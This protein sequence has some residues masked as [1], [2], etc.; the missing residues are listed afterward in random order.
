MKYLAR[1][2]SLAAG[3]LLSASSLV[4]AQETWTL[5]R[6]I[7][8]AQENNLS[9]M[10]ARATVRTA[11]LS[12]R[13][14]R[15]GRL[16]TVDGQI[17]AGEQFGRTIDPTT[18]Q[19]S[20]TAVGYNSMGL[21]AGASLF[22]GGLVHHRIKQAGFE[23]QAAEADAEQE[24]N[25]LALRVAQAYLSILLGQEQTEIAQRRVEQSRRQLEQTDKLIQAGTL[26][27]A[28]RFNIVAQIARDEQA[29]VVAQNT[30]ELGY[31]SLKQLLQL[32]PDY[33]MQIERPAVALPANITDAEA[34]T[35][36]SLYSTAQ[37]TQPAIRAGDFRLRSAQTAIDIA[38]S[39]YFPTLSVFANLSTNYS[40][41]FASSRVAVQR[42][43]STIYYET[44]PQ[45]PVVI[46]SDQPVFL[47]AD[48]IP[49]FKQ[50]EQN[51]GQQVGV[52]LR[53]PIYQNNRV[54]LSVERARLA[55]LNTELQNDLV[56]QQ[57]K[58]DIQTAIA[59]VRAGRQ[60][61]EA[62]QRTLDATRMAFG[63]TERRHQL[64]A[65]TTLEL[66]TARTNLDVAENDLVVARY[67]Y[68]F[69]LK[70]LDFYQGKPL[71]M[72]Q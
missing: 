43:P 25:D 70:I 34:L 24:S 10:Q 8:H 16:P 52:S 63:N 57:L 21:S 30:V 54:R 50:L 18:N 36:G 47:G 71:S 35:L 6:A 61:Y 67:E 53:V 31:L 60:Q 39:A 13:A 33:A 45:T 37:T 1:V 38:R 19:F 58:N 40:S 62:A 20:T 59:N 5:E 46:Y 65:A 23:V 3:I 64:G 56:R 72:N 2:L 48:D 51:F 66:T 32:E 27:Q 22:Q 14:E 69:R 68:L 4:Q 49:Y 15:A 41:G 42:V 12:E 7:Q 26:P 28:D 44:D 9:L 55:V 11:L 29:I 17:N